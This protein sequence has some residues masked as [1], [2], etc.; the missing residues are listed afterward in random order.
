[1][2]HVVD[3]F[4][5]D[6][7]VGTSSSATSQSTSLIS[8]VYDIPQIS[9]WATSKALDDPVN[10]PRFMRTIPTDDAIAFAICT[11]WRS[12]G[13]EFAAV[14]YINDPYGEAY[15]ESTIKHCLDLG[16]QNI[17][18]FAITEVETDEQTIGQV[19]KL[20]ETKLRV[21][22]YIDFTRKFKVVMEAAYR[23]GIIGK[24]YT[25]TF[26]ESVYTNDMATLSPE[27]RRAVD[28]SL[29]VFAPGGTEGNER[30]LNF[31][32]DWKTFDYTFVNSYWPEPFQVNHTFFTHPERD[33]LNLMELRIPGVYQYDAVAALGL[34]ACAIN[35]KADPL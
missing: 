6:A 31:V 15:K 18:S 30:W 10:H 12:L 24:G 29:R 20:A 9:Y 27:V 13:Y 2:I 19:R 4:T 21:F 17:K 34:I 32:D 7:V 23:F 28:G 35:P 8:G 5:A 25:W 14:L 11:F 22:L 1:M 16:M 3:R 26:G 33:L